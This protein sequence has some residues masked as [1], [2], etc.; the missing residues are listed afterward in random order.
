MSL[1]SLFTTVIGL[2][3]S[4]E[5]VITSSVFDAYLP[6]QRWR[7]N[8]RGSRS[9][10]TPRGSSSSA[11]RPRHESSIAKNYFEIELDREELFAI[12]LDMDQRGPPGQRKS[13]ECQSPQTGLEHVCQSSRRDSRVSTNPVVRIGAERRV[14]RI[15]LHLHPQ[16]VLSVSPCGRLAFRSTVLS[17]VQLSTYESHPAHQ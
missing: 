15:R 9:G 13:P 14:R 2:Q 16:E 12:E 17:R 10:R 5:G 7:K 4:P 1:S 3:G 8:R 6:V 11:G